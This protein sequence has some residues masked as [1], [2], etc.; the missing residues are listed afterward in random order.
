M[1]VAVVEPASTHDQASGP[2][3]SGHEATN[4]VSEWIDP[5]GDD[6]FSEIYR[7]L[8]QDTAGVAATTP[9]VEHWFG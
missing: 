3:D 7:A 6:W 2:R 9:E 8:I 1:N 5:E 4:S